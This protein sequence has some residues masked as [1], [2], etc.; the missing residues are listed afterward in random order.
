MGDLEDRQ[1][2]IAGW[3]EEKRPD[4]ATAYSSAIGLLHSS[5]DN[6]QER[7]R[8]M[9][10]CHSMR[11][12]MNRLPTAVML[13][14][15]SLNDERVK[16]HR[17]SADQVREL[18][19][20]RVD[21]PDMDLTQ[22]AENIP[23]PREAAAVFDRLIETAVYEDQRRLSDLAAFLTDDAN[24]KHPAVREWRGLSDYFVKWAH[25]HDKT[26]A[27]VPTDKELT[28]KIRVFED[29]VD[30]IRLVFFE[31]KSVIED[32]LAAANQTVEEVQP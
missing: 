30:A 26:D 14:R 17:R 19:Q 23:V 9:L 11:E 20:L 3:L 10:I 5:P 28:Q 4:L 29:H 31:S 21:H 6:G 12:V 27:S 24:P 25:L 8:I 15:G 22:D 7:T 2:V 18:P 16:E 1:R 13:S 32:L